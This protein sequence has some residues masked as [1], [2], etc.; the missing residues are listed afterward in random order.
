MPDKQKRKIP[1]TLVL[2]R[3][4]QI[5]FFLILP[6]LFTQVLTSLKTGAGLPWE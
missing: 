3:A 6:G 5:L 4:S 2:R 1:A